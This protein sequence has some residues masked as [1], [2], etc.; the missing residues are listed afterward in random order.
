MKCFSGTSLNIG[1]LKSVPTCRIKQTWDSSWFTV[2]LF[3]DTCH[4]VVGFLLPSFLKR[5]QLKVVRNS[6]TVFRYIYFHYKQIVSWASKCYSSVKTAHS[7]SYLTC[8]QQLRSKLPVIRHHRINI[9]QNLG[10]EGRAKW[11]LARIRS[12]WNVTMT[13]L[14]LN[15]SI[16]SR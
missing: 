13:D 8:H 10:Q 1:L 6:V 12:R 4:F 7:F 3:S 15:L 11:C 16:C 14:P 2:F 9:P 5:R